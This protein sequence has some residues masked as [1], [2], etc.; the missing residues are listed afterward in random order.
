MATHQFKI[1]DRITFLHEDRRGVV[2]DLLSGNQVLIEDEDGFNLKTSAFN[3]CLIY[4]DIFSVEGIQENKISEEQEVP[5]G[6]KKS[7]KRKPVDIWEID[8]HAHE[9]LDSTFG[10]TN[11][12]ILMHQL[13]VFKNGLVKARK[14]K[15]RFV[16]V[17]HGVG[18]GVLK[19]ALYDY[20]K[21]QDDISFEDANPLEYGAGASLVKIHY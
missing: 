21:T 18:K 20:L 5:K 2:K 12:D 11:G 15:I 17:I 6:S 13:Q 19:A 4:C 1:G 3:I 14:Q 9:L 8:L 16:I 7:G 10:M